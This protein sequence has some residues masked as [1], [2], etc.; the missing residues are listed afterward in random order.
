MVNLYVTICNYLKA[1]VKKIRDNYEHEGECRFRHNGCILPRISTGYCESDI[2]A[3]GGWA[4]G[5]SIG[6]FANMRALKAEER[7]AKRKA[8]FEDLQEIIAG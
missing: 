1:A 8:F 7:R 2:E 6:C 5:K 4:E 3:K